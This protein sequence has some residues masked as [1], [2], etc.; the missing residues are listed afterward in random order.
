MWYILYVNGANLMN[1]NDFDAP[2]TFPL[3]S[4][5]GQSLHSSCETSHHLLDG[6]TQNYVDTFALQAIN[7]NEFSNT[8]VLTYPPVPPWSS[9][10]WFSNEM[11]GYGLDVCNINAYCPPG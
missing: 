1:P 4:P 8:L 10:L 11:Y 7:C 5:G 2:P 3:T 9:Q 6:L